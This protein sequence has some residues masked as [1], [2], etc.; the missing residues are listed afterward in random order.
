MAAPNEKILTSPNMP[1]D[2]DAEA[3]VLAA[4][5][6]SEETLQEA[7]TELTSEDFFLPRNQVL[8][9][10]LRDMFDAGIHP[11]A[12]TIIDW[13]TSEGTLDR[14]GGK[15]HLSQLL[16]IPPALTAFHQHTHILRRDAVL[17]KVLFASNSMAELA[18]NAPKDTA[19]LID[20]AEKL[21]FE[22]TE[23]EISSKYVTLEDSLSDLFVELQHQADSGEHIIGV[24]TGF[25]QLDEHLLGLRSG[26]MVVVGARP[27]VGKTSFALNLAVQAAEHGAAV[28]LFSLEMGANEIA[29]RLLSSRSQVPLQ[30]IRGARIAQEEWAQIANA[31]EE[32]SKLDIMIDDSP[33]TTMTEIRAKARRMLHDKPNGLII[34][35]Y[36]QLLSPAPGAANDS[37]AT[38]V[39]EMSRGVKIMAKDLG[40]PVVALSQLSRKSEERV[41]KRPQLSDLRESGAIEQDADIVVLLDRSLTDEE[42][43]RKDR[44]DK[45]MT[46]FL[47]AKNRSGPTGII[48]MYF[49]GDS[50]KFVEIERSYPTDG[51]PPQPQPQQAAPAASAQQAPTQS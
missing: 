45:G 1:H 18:L 29:P 39:S 24:Q 9:E 37:R 6:F 47:I 8:F 7:L 19:E 30:R 25:K 49:M 50:T 48:S 10:A 27:S 34:I 15:Q 2:E 23:S 40:V 12:V 43:A 11:E 5:I 16:S 35:D 32:L 3:L 36:L 41:G 14:A 20:K 22:A 38:M 42:A 31:T 44:P 51:E 28:A 13:L 21:I 33:G 4:M 46:D 17:R 26:Q